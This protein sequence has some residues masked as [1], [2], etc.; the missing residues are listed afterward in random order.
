VTGYLVLDD[1]STLNL[2]RAPKFSWS[3]GFDFTKDMGSGKFSLS[4]LFRFTD[5]YS[6]CLIESRPVTLGAVTN[7]RRCDSGPRE[8]LDITASY[9]LPMGDGEAKISLFARNLLDDRG[10]SSTLPVAGL[11][12]F[13]GLRPP[14]QLGGEIQFK[15]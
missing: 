7:E 5:R 14:R 12:T 1:V 6:T 15:F 13:S 8:I 10:I 11:F 9:T 4:P 3:A 2:R